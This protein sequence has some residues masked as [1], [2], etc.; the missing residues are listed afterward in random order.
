M[1]KSI[2]LIIVLLL[3]SCS[4]KKAVVTNRL[5]EV[6]VT[7]NDGGAPIEF[8]EILSEPKEVSMLL[9]DP[10]LRKLIQPNDIQKCN[11]V[12]LNLGGK[13]QGFYSIKIESITETSDTIVVKIKK[14]KPTADT[15][16]PDNMIYPFTVI[17]I[18]SKK[19]IVFQ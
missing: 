2:A 4:S 9:A 5:Y 15:V 16:N 14:P 6:L 17:K 13:A 19:P 11:Y 8:Y 10:D 7:K 1:K 12:I 18:N 3:I